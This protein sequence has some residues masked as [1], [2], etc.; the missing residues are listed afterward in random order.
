MGLRA[1]TALVG[2][3]AAAAGVASLLARSLPIAR[4]EATACGMIFS[5]AIFAALGLW[6]FHEAKLSRVVLLIWG[7][8]AACI[9]VTAMLGPRV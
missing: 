2:G 4:V 7:L 5:F 9:A 3:Y 8:S 1:F 6:A